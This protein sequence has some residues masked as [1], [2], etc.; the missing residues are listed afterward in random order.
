MPRKAGPSTTEY[1]KHRAEL[2]T[3]VLDAVR[4][5]APGLPSECSAREIAAYLEERNIEMSLHGIAQRLVSLR[6]QGLVTGRELLQR[7]LWKP[8]VKGRSQRSEIRGQRSE[9]RC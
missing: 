9:V 6:Q 4:V 7:H 1:K 3:A 8:T 2:D 5:L